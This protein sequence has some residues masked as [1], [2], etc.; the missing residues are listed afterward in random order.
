MIGECSR[1]HTGA[2]WHQEGAF[3][4]SGKCREKI[5]CFPWAVSSVSLQLDNTCAVWAETIR[6][7]HEGVRAECNAHFTA[8]SSSARWV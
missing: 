4:K 5:W 1:T 7:Y 3:K 8:D 6:I 2:V